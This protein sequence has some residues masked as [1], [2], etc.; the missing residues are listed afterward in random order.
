MV[1]RRRRLV[2]EEDAGVQQQGTGHAQQLPLTH[3]EVL[4]P[5]YHIFVETGGELGDVG[6]DSR[7]GERERERER[8]REMRCGE[9]ADA[10]SGLQNDVK[11]R[12]MK[13]G[14]RFAG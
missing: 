3:A 13:N 4:A 1:E 7:L 11:V 2:E 6:F 9:D 8:E 10:V 12:R 5:L 14:V